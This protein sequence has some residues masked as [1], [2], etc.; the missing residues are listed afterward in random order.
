MNLK[1]WTILAAGVCLIAVLS[2]CDANDPADS[3][4]VP[5]ESLPGVLET[6][7]PAD[8]ETPDTGWSLDKNTLT[9]DYLLDLVIGPEIALIGDNSFTFHNPDDLS[10]QE[11][12]ILFL[13]LTEYPELETHLNK[14]DQQFYFTSEVITTQLK[15]YFRN[16]QFDITEVNNYDEEADAVI[17]PLASGFGGDRYMKVTDKT[18]S[19]NTVTFTAEFYEDYEIEG[20]V[21]QTKTY[22]IEF[23]DGGYYYLSAVEQ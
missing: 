23:Y 22:S 4:A 1:H 16:F 20:T 12:Y 15:R 10:S 2:A 13:F 11:L 21:Y 3:P 7:A 18:I 8:T 14:D 9:D 6:T 5:S 17:T 19:G